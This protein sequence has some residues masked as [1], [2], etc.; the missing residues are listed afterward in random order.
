VQSYN[1]APVDQRQFDADQMRGIAE[2]LATKWPQQPEADEAWFNLGTLALRSG[3]FVEGADFLEKISERSA[4]R[5]EANLKAGQALWA[6]SLAQRPVSPD[7]S[8]E[9]LPTGEELASRAAELLDRGIAAAR[10]NASRSD[11]TQALLTSAT[12]TRVQ[13]HVARS[14]FP[15]AIDLI[16]APEVGLL[17]LASS[18]KSS[19]K[20]KLEA[21]K[22]ALQAYVSTQQLDKAQHAMEQLEALAADDD[23]GGDASLLAIYLNLGRQLEQQVARLRS[24]GQ[25]E[26]LDGVL[27]SFEQ[28]IDRVAQR[29]DAGTFNSLNWAAQSYLSLA[30]GL[31][32]GSSNSDR[33]A[34]KYYRQAAQTYSKILEAARNNPDFVPEPRYLTHVKVR[35]AHCTRLMGDYPKA[36]DLLVD[37]LKRRPSTLQAQIEAAETYQDWAVKDAKHYNSAIHGARRARGKD[38]AVVNIVWGWAKLASLA[39]R[40]PKLRAAYHQAR[41]ALAECCFRE[42]KSMSGAEKDRG[43]QTA[44]Q[45]ITATVRLDPDLGDAQQRQ[46]YDRLLKSIQTARGV[47]PTGLSKILDEIRPTTG[48]VSRDVR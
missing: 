33:R 28:F 5:A 2:Y 10:K 6:A 1:D 45:V 12:L 26:Q 35:R 31:S 37:L 44:E 21:Q 14:E 32:S 41:L 30:S 7:E 16:E 19:A 15:A 18:K 3:R 13:I 47:N 36:V 17:A 29:G 40:N 8:D 24:A 23:S 25:S 11:S 43:L 39:A 20:S 42:A 38:G 4:L 48:A 46:Q 34:A 27:K 9:A 22:L